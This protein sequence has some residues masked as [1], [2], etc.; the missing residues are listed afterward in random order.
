MASFL[1]DSTSFPIHPIPGRSKRFSRTWPAHPALWK[2]SSEKTGS[3]TGKPRTR[4][5]SDET[6]R[7]GAQTHELP[8]SDA[9][10]C[11]DDGRQKTEDRGQRT[12]D[13]RARSARLPTVFCPL[14]SGSTRIPEKEFPEKWTSSA[15]IVTFHD[16]V[17]PM[18]A[19]SVTESRFCGYVFFNFQET[20]MTSR[21]EM[22]AEL[23]PPP[24]M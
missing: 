15:K 13:S 4:L 6:C 20:M 21:T 12:V 7:K 8:G 24:P 10:S 1:S 5:N 9:N 18:T 22:T 17:A 3:P 14:L 16:R 2:P 23:T 11:P 19:V